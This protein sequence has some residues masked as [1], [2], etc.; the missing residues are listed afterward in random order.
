MK[1]PLGMKVKIG[2]YPD[3]GGNRKIEVKIHK[4]DLYSLDYTL[5]LIILPA[6]KEFRKGVRSSP[7]I[8]FEDVPKDLCTTPSN[9]YK[10]DANWHK[11][12]EYVLDEMIFAFE[13]IAE[14]KEAESDVRIANGLRLFGKYYRGLWY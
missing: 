1:V 4:H 11:R 12:W 13:C 2:N 7:N 14:D 6:L 5:A 8:D 3:G 9:Q 10:L